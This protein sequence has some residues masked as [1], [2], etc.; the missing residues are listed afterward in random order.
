MIAAA[1][2]F[3][4]KLVIAVAFGMLDVCCVCANAGAHRHVTVHHDGAEMA[5]LRSQVDVVDVGHARAAVPL[6][7]SCR[8]LPDYLGS[9]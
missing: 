5:I 6:D 4:G 9:R 8:N 2:H 7:V 3:V 1:V